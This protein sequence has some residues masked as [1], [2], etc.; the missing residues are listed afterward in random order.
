[1]KS[2]I[3]RSLSLF[4]AALPSAPLVLIESSNRGGSTAGEKPT[5]H[6]V[7]R[8][9]LIFSPGLIH[10]RALETTGNAAALAQF[11]SKPGRRC[12]QAWSVD[13]VL[14]NIAECGSDIVLEKENERLLAERG[15]R[16]ERTRNVR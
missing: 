1:L 15:W 8:L 14:A 10:Q 11:L 16:L 3:S 7:R 2:A 9:S 6:R 5:R 4:G 13:G 12:W